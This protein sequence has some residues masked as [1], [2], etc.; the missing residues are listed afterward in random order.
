MQSTPMDFVGSSEDRAEKTSSSVKVTFDMLGWDKV[1][2]EEEGREELLRQDLYTEWKNEL[3]SSA[4][5]RSVDALIELWTI[6]EGIELFFGERPYVVVNLWITITSKACDKLRFVEWFGSLDFTAKFWIL[7][8]VCCKGRMWD[9]WILFYEE[10]GDA[11]TD[12]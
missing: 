5:S 2:S 1:G 11:C 9:F 12:V 3:K 6:V 10:Y 8:Q 4:F 7:F